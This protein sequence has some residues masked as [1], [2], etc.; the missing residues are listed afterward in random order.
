MRALIASVAM[1]IVIGCSAVPAGA[2][3]MSSALAAEAF[4]LC[5]SVDRIPP[6]DPQA[7]IVRLE[8][9]VRLSEAAVATDAEDA[10]AHLALFCNLGRQ[11]DLAGLG[12]RTF[13][14]LRRARVAINRAY[15]LA[16]R[17]P[18]VLVAKGEMLRRLPAA[19][20]G[21]KVTG[22]A[23]LGRA[24][25]LDPDNVSARLRLARAMAADRAPDA[26]ARIHEA[27]TLAEQ[28]GAEIEQSEARALLAS[29][30]Q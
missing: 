2:N 3:E 21:D 17:D 19:L 1:T 13:G 16:P 6:A 15:E 28:R 24:V 9:A 30:D 20:G 11:L 29:L 4:A 22:I 23:L 25:E 8:E 14:R 18:D 10:R 5:K 12:W 27:L 7:T 26:R